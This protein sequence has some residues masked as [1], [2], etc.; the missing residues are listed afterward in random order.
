MNISKSAFVVCAL[1]V[2]MLASACTTTPERRV[3]T[4][5][6]VFEQFDQ[7]TQ[8]KILAGEVAIGFTPEMTYLAL[9]DPDRKV[10]RTSK[11]GVTERWIYLGYRS[12]TYLTEP[13]WSPVYDWYYDP[14]RGTYVRVRAP[15]HPRHRFG[16]ISE[17][18]ERAVVSFRDDR[19]VAFERSD[20][21]R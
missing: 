8:Q 7:E 9:G 14:H 13:Y 17:E 15:L 1:I 12:R 16:S 18:Y 20:R 4:N 6:E 11:E 2:L 10:T 5:P 21:R 19:V 3:A